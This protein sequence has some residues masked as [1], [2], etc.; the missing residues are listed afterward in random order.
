M[1]LS[2]S[3]SDCDISWT[4][5]LVCILALCFAIPLIYV[6]YIAEHTHSGG[7]A[8]DGGGVVHHAEDHHASP[9]SSVQSDQHWDA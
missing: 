1:D 4:V 3:G 9:A 7:A 2:C 8:D 6:L 5:L